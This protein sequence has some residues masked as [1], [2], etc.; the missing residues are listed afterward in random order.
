MLPGKYNEI[1]GKMMII[2]NGFESKRKN[3]VH[4][5]LFFSKKTEKGSDLQSKNE[6]QNNKSAI[7]A[8]NGTY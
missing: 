1:D 4:N 7:K 3:G 8:I 5:T 2:L 6:S